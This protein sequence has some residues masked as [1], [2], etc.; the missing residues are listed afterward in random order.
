MLEVIPEIGTGK[1]PNKNSYSSGFRGLGSRA[2]VLLIDRT[3]I[4]EHK[5][6]L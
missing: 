4:A 6:L 2:W 5:V 3:Q 1:E